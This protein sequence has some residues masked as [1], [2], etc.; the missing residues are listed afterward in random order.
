[1]AYKNIV[2]ELRSKNTY[3]EQLASTHAYNNQ[4]LAEERDKVLIILS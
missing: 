3:L 4:I 1:M 2:S